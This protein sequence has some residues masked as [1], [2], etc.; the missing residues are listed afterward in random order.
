M[1]DTVPHA[2]STKAPKPARRVPL[3][4][5]SGR[6]PTPGLP[7]EHQ[8]P[9]IICKDDDFW[10]ED[11]NIILEVGRVHFRVHK[12]I[13]RAASSNNPNS[14]FVKILAGPPPPNAQLFEGVPTIK[15][16]DDPEDLRL[17]LR[18]ILPSPR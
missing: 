16:T 8:L 1:E 10:Y 9:Y 12:S 14:P 2:R 11:G 18:E 7:G 4:S 6:Q 15:L 3:N 5:N 13:L 17:A